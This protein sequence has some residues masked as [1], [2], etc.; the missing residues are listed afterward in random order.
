MLRRARIHGNK[1]GAT[2]F[3]YPWWFITGTV[4]LALFFW[5]VAL[6]GY[7]DE[8]SP[9]LVGIAGLIA[10]ALSLTPVRCAYYR[11]EL[12]AEHV[13]MRGFFGWRFSRG[14][15]ELE[16]VRQDSYGKLSFYFRGWGRLPWERRLEH[17]LLD[18]LGFSDMMFTIVSP[19]SKDI[20]LKECLERALDGLRLSA[21]GREKS[22]K[23]GGVEQVSGKGAVEATEK[24]PW[25][26]DQG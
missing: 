23:I 18:S 17:W 22:W 16:T 7:F 13:R 26:Q 11:L 4:L 9:S 19:I 3:R 21:D 20:R 5:A 12:D 8:Q 15:T 10:M 25:A 6:L 1:S 2:V 14:Y 24:G